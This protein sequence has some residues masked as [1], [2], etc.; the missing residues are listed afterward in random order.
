ML[1]EGVP[2]GN[3][4]ATAQTL[5]LVFVPMELFCF[6]C[7]RGYQDCADVMGKVNLENGLCAQH[8]YQHREEH[9]SSQ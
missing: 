3:D 7:P 9:P 4:M 2:S 5:S 8:R 1:R 6:L